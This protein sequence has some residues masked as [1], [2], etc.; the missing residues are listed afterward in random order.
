MNL[1]E[2]LSDPVAPIPNLPVASNGSPAKPREELPV[3]RVD[4]SDP[5][6]FDA[7][8]LASLL[9]LLDALPAPVSDATQMFGNITRQVGDRPPP[10]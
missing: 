1:P 7:S 2:L 6:R 4:L 5:D 3:D 8:G 10:G 9:S